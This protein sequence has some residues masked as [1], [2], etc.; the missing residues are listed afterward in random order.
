[1]VSVMRELTNCFKKENPLI[2]KKLREVSVE[3]G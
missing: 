1:M 2:Q 3:E